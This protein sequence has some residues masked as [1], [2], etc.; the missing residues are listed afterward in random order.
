MHLVL[1]KAVIINNFYWRLWEFLCLSKSS[2]IS[3]LVCIFLLCILQTAETLQG[4]LFLAADIN[5]CA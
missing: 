1:D 5:V 4:L 2:E 3:L